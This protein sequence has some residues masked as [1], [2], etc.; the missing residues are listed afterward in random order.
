MRPV[1][2]ADQRRVRL[3]LAL[4]LPLVVHQVPHAQIP[5]R[6][7]RYHALPVIVERRVADELA[8]SR[9]DFLQVVLR[10]SVPSRRNHS[11][12]QTMITV[13]KQTVLTV[14]KEAVLSIQRETSNALY[15]KG[16]EQF[17]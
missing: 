6:G 17:V 13:L 3:N 7:G 10:M 1:H 12:K 5:V 4:K 9:R 2:T 14:L 15:A 16:N 8:M 11:V